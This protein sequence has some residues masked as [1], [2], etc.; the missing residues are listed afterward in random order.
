MLYHPVQGDGALHFGP[1]T[2]VTKR[3]GDVTLAALPDFAPVPLSNMETLP[4]GVVKCTM[5]KG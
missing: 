5:F 2:S 3:T 1:Q 4:K